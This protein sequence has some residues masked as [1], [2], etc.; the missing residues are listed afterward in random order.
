MAGRVLHGLRA[1]PSGCRH[2]RIAG[3][4]LPAKDEASSE[5]AGEADGEAGGEADDE[6][7]VGQA[8]EARQ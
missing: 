7:T 6:Q 1:V 8:G 4:C 5:A 3:I 2:C